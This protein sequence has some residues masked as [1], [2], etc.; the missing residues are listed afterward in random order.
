MNIQERLDVFLRRLAAAPPARNADDAMSL[1]CGL[2]EEVEDEF[3]PLP[4]EEPPPLKFTGRMYAPRKD[5][6]RRLSQGTLVADT[7]HHRVYCQAD[8]AI[9]ILHMPDRRLVIAKGGRKS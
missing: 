1:V 3:C 7:R 9:S 4:R 2:I 6:M 8:G 5:H